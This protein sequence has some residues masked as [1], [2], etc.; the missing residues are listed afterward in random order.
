M[1]Y[2]VSKGLGRGHPAKSDT[3]RVLTEKQWRLVLQ[4]AGDSKTNNPR[5]WHRDYAM[6]YLGYMLG[7]RIG[8]VV[9]LS[10]D[11]F[12]DL[13]R[14]DVAYLPTLKQSGRILVVCHGDASSA[15][16][17]TA[18][19]RYTAVRAAATRTRCPTPRARRPRASW[20]ASRA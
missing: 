5:F 13:E 1:L 4:A 10:R 3:E 12:R 17:W 18:Q 15:S 2:L 9:Q 6:L 19:A 11:H 16:A 8:E 14:L 7:M 20:N